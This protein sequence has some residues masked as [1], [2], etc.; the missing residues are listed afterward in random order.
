MQSEGPYRAE[1]WEGQ[2]EFVVVG[3]GWENR[4]GTYTKNEAGIAARFANLAHA[5]GRK[6][7]EKEL[8]KM[9]EELEVA[10]RLLEGRDRLLDLFECK[11][12]GQGC[13]PDAVEK[14]IKMQKDFQELL[15][16]TSRKCYRDGDRA[17]FIAWKKARGL[18]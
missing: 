3:P 13:V 14:V 9:K 7:T 15:E 12:H 18:K 2:N 8:D 6:S 11:D 1:H 16:F 4:G 5:E 17:D 10:N